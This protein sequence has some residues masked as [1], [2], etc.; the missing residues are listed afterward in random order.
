[1]VVSSLQMPT[2][3]GDRGFSGFSL[4][5]SCAWVKTL[6]EYLLG[7]WMDGRMTDERIDG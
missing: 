5:C 6:C 7:E 1:M 2:P 3:R 4:C